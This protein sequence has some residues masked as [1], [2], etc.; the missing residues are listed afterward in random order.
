MRARRGS[1]LGRDCARRPARSW[2]RSEVGNLNAWAGGQ[3]QR[4]PCQLLRRGSFLPPP[5]PS[6]PFLLLPVFLASS[7]LHPC[8]ASFLP[9]RPSSL[10]SS[11]RRSRPGGQNPPARGYLRAL[12]VAPRSASVWSPGAHSAARPPH[13][14]ASERPQR[15]LLSCSGPAGRGSALASQPAPGGSVVNVRYSHSGAAAGSLSSAW[16]P[17]PHPQGLGRGLGG[18][19][20]G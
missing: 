8:P 3:V 11:C 1:V 9:P 5:S 7:L 19:G 13:P 17:L 14:R 2:E 20:C 15:Q 10:P 18:Q 12:R 6:S 4:F 16:P